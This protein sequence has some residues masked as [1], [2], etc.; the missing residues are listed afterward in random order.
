MT[1]EILLL[2]NDTVAVE[3]KR[4]KHVS[5]SHLISTVLSVVTSQYRTSILDNK[6][7]AF[8]SCHG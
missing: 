7:R 8:R 4:C 1:S 6:D 5:I 2:R 3:G